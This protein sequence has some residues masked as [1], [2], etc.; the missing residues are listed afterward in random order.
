MDD[1]S[2]V[3]HRLAAQAAPLRGAEA[4]SFAHGAGHRPD[5]ATTGGPGR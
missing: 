2:R 4:A 1:L 3:V 5:V